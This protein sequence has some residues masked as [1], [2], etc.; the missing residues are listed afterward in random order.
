MKSPNV[1]RAVA[2]GTSVI[3]SLEYVLWRWLA[4][5]S[6]RYFRPASN[7]SRSPCGKL[8][9]TLR[10]LSQATAWCLK[11]IVPA[12][13]NGLI[14]ERRNSSVSFRSC[15]ICFPYTSSLAWQRPRSAHFLRPPWLSPPPP[16]DSHQ[17]ALCRH[18]PA[19]K[20]LLANSP[21][22]RTAR[23]LQSTQSHL[24]HCAD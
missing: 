1:T 23:G 21:F 22:A 20:I 6:N 5:Y 10:A 18:A 19:T 7:T 13:S 16:C 3:F 9:H 4:I 12:S 2:F 17:L 8:F 11:D 14:G 15:S 24:V